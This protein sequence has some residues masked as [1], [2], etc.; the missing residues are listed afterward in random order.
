MEFLTRIQEKKAERFLQE[1]YTHY[2]ENGKKD[3]D[4]CVYLG[5]SYLML[6]LGY[7]IMEKDNSVKIERSKNE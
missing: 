5:A 4:Y 2:L 3:K 7:A 6:K 1:R